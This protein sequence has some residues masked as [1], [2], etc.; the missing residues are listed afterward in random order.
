VPS[1]AVQAFLLSW[2][3][4]APLW[5]QCSGFSLWWLLL[6]LNT[7]SRAG[8]LSLAAGLIVV[9][10]GLRCSSVCGILLDQR[11]N[12]CL[13]PWQADS[14]SLPLSHQGSPSLFFFNFFPC[15]FPTVLM[16]IT[17]QLAYFPS[18]AVYL[19]LFSDLSFT[20]YPL[21]EYRTFFLLKFQSLSC[22]NSNTFI[23]TLRIICFLRQLLIFV[24]SPPCQ[25]T[26]PLKTRIIVY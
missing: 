17:G 4:G 19:L 25:I 21:P 9:A 23:S 22:S 7:G 11:S 20:L 10:R 24:S 14:D 18:L 26:D 2:R 5:L 8:R 15:T 13:L 6:L 3:A 16:Y 12:S 1:V